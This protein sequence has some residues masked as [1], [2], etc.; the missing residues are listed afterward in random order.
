MDAI[1]YSYADKQ[2]KRIKKI[3]ANPD[4]TSGV[5]TFPKVIASGETITIPTGRAAILPNVRVDGTLALESGADVFVPAGG[6]FGDIDTRLDGLDTTVATKANTSDMTTALGLKANTSDLKE[7][8]VGQTW[9]DV[10]VSRTYN[11]VYTNSTGK[12]IKVS[13]TITTLA[14]TAASFQVESS[15][16]SGVYLTCTVDSSSA[17]VG[18]NHGAV[19]PAGFRYKMVTT[20]TPTLGSWIELR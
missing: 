10:K 17:G 9:Q 1:S 2:A 18:S 3:V 14:G 4:S 12:P 8:G 16:G 13:I 7:I 5:V 6:T 11:T 20:N 19:V 15:L